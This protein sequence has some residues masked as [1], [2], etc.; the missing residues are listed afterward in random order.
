L[1]FPFRETGM[2]LGVL[3]VLAVLSESTI[4][5]DDRQ[6]PFGSCYGNVSVSGVSSGGMMAVQAHFAYSDTVIGAGI[7]A[8]GPYYCAQGDLVIAGALMLD[9]HLI[10]LKH[11]Y[12]LTAEAEAKK[13][14]APTSNLA[15]ARTWLFHGSKDTV[16]KELIMEKVAAQY[17]NYQSSY[18]QMYTEWSVPAEHSMVTDDYGQDCG[19]LHS[20]FINN[21][22]YSAAGQMLSFIYNMTLNPRIGLNQS[23]IVLLNQ[24]SFIPANKTSHQHGLYSTAVAY[25]P[26]SCRL[27]NAKCTLHVAFHGCLTTIPEVGDVVYLHAGMNEW[28]ETNDFIILYPQATANLVN[29]MGCWDWWGYSGEDYAFNTGVQL[30]TVKNMIDYF[31]GAE[32]A[33]S[34]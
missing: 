1:L 33:T 15:K 18:E 28:A 11:L 4:T 32:S 9:P 22:N 26:T 21:C 17:T 34:D 13:L 29:P 8:G 24:L 30:S 19:K 12:K 20:P 25:I 3:F 16:V 14:I 2:F 10:D 6:W 7:I 23:N 5:R 27:P 31:I